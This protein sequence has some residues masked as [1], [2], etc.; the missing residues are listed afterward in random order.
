MS[1]PRAIIR[2]EPERPPVPRFGGRWKTIMLPLAVLTPILLA[3]GIFLLLDK[4]EPLAPKDMLAKTQWTSDELGRALG[5]SMSP[6]FDRNQRS[7]VQRH[8]YQQVKN[9]SPEERRQVNVAAVH[10]AIDE[11]LAQLRAMPG[12]KRREMMDKLNDRAFDN[13]MK[14]QN[15]PESKRQ[16]LRNALDSEGAKA[17]GGEIVNAVYGKLTP[18]ERGELGP[19]IK[20]W[21]KT[22]DVLEK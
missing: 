1:E 16:E 22:I 21:I 19:T 9:L 13:Y 7:N 17:V 18:A 2:P 6:H 5:R 20:L 3:I 10:Y 15:M 11:T 4:P 12:D 14:I 8:L